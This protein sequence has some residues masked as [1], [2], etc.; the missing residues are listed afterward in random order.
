MH[1]EVSMG[2]KR[3]FIAGIIILVAIIIIL[4]L[5]GREGNKPVPPKEEIQAVGESQTSSL[6]KSAVDIASHTEGKEVPGMISSAGALSDGEADTEK[7]GDDSPPS[8]EEFD[9]VAGFTSETQMTSEE[10]K[11]LMEEKKE[12]AALERGPEAL[13]DYQKRK[14]AREEEKF[15]R[16][17]LRQKLREYNDERREWK[18][19]IDEARDRARQ[20]GDFAEVD[21]LRKMRPEPPRRESS[22]SGDQE[23]N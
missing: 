2:K 20:T 19:L 22:P 8:A 12:A 18:R 7:S 21:E 15:T 4:S 10:F 5:I 1:A 9:S 11:A 14:E 6:Q 23:N 16:E 3:T 13:E 17:E